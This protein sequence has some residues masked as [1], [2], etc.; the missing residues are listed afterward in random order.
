MLFRSHEGPIAA[1]L[2]PAAFESQQVYVQDRFPNVIVALDGTVIAAWN[3]VQVRR[4][5]DG[6]RTWGEPIPIARGF[7]GGG[8]LVD[9]ISGDVLAFLEEKHPP[10]PIQVFRSKDH[11][12]TWAKQ[13]A[14]FYPNSFGHLPSLHMN[15]HGITLRHGPY[16]GRLIRPS[17][18]YGRSNSPAEMFPTHYTNALFSD[19]GGRS[20][21]ASEPFPV[22]E[23]GRASCRERV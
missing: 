19:D 14:V 5:T 7:M 21:K 6:G 20:W 15:E 10:A 18:W 12:R 23:I 17:R 13:D 4:S 16:K 9:E 22:M 11:G 1:F 3:G 2:R 8:F